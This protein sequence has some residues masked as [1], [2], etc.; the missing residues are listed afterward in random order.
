MDTKNKHD[1]LVPS[2]V[3]DL[4][5]RMDFIGNVPPNYKVCVNYRIYV[6]SSFKSTY[7]YRWY[8][9]ETGSTTCEFIEKIIS[10]MF[11][12]LS[13]ENHLD[14]R[15]RDKIY[16]KSAIFRNGIINLIS[17]YSNNPD[18][19]SKLRTSKDK[20]ELKIPKKMLMITDEISQEY[21]S[22]EGV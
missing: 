9:G 4:L 1:L 22:D 18:A 17:T 15:L 6:D 13:P 8:L 5:V 14:H 19:C 10:D 21:Y 16:E 7:F 3:T 12:L 2:H 11:Q 20:I